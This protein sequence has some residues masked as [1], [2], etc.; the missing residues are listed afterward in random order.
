MIRARL[1]LRS[2]N[3]WSLNVVS[4]WSPIPTA[5]LALAL[6]VRDAPSRAVRTSRARIEARVRIIG[7]LVGIGLGSRA[8]FLV[9]PL[10]NKEGGPEFRRHPSEKCPGGPASGSGPWP[11]R[12]TR[13]AV[14]TE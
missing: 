8:R 3:S 14:P 10:L 11:S 1:I 2:L 6:V 13:T 12:G 5:I 7:L 9:A 4:F